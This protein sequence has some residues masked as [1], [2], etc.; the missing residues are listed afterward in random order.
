MVYRM[1]SLETVAKCHNERP[2]RQLPRED[3]WAYRAGS[4]SKDSILGLNKRII[5]S[6]LLMAPTGMFTKR[7]TEM[8]AERPYWR[9]ISLLGQCWR[10]RN[11][12]TDGHH[13][14]ATGCKRGC[15]ISRLAYKAMYEGRESANTPEF[16]CGM[17][18][19]FMW[20]LRDRCEA[21]TMIE[22]FTEITV[23]NSADDIC[24][25]Q[26][27]SARLD[28]WMPDILG[29]EIWS[30][31]LLWMFLLS[32]SL[33]FTSLLYYFGFQPSTNGVAMG[34]YHLRR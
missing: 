5:G 34:V 21:H 24:L 2:L 8:N 29:V 12:T 10:R 13:V 1:A 28:G 9:P 33:L 25:L 3:D 17:N 15:Q 23:S 4:R 19:H 26:V 22:D 32:L 30:T 6:P 7:L 11:I 27:T 20:S 31:V 14:R 18:V 16:I